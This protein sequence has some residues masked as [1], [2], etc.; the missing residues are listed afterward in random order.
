MKKD[1]MNVKEIWVIGVSLIFDKD[2]FS[3][4]KF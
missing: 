4:K 1:I 2:E 3:F